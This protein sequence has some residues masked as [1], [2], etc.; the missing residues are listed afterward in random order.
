MVLTPADSRDFEKVDPRRRH[1]RSIMSFESDSTKLG[2]IP[3]RKWANTGVGGAEGGW[4]P[5]PYFPLE[6]YR[7]PEVEKGRWG[8]RR[9]FGRGG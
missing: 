3:E 7:E 1:R 2:E 6:P 9:L 8:F 4:E 5:R